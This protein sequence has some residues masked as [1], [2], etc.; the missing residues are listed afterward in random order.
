MKLDRL[1]D[2]FVR[3]YYNIHLAGLQ[4]FQQRR[5]LLGGA[6]PREVVHTDGHI[7]QSGGKRLVVLIGQHRGGNQHSHLFA[8][9]GSFEGGAHG[10][11]GLAKAHVATDQSV[12]GLGFLHVGLDVVG[13]LQLV[14][15]VFVEERR[16]QLV[17]HIRVGRES[18]A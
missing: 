16:L 11:L 8:V 15:G 3:T 12:H 10:H 6:S 9:Y 5:S 4:V 14:G 1:A 7:L 18:E 13:G 2:E 17:L